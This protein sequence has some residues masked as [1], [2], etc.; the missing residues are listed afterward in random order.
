MTSLV[1]GGSGFIGSWLVDH[2]RARGETVT[3]LTRQAGDVLDRDGLA[4]LLTETKP[5]KI[6]HLAAQ[7][8][9]GPSWNEPAHTFHVNI[10]GTLNLLEAVRTVGL[11]PAIV[12]ACSSSEYK[13][14]D[15]PIKETDPMQPS[16]PYAVSKLGVD[17]IARLYAARYG[18]KVIRARPF[19]LIGPR[20]TGD[21]CSDF[22]RGIVAIEKGQAE[23]LSVGRLDMVRDFLDVRDGATAFDV[24]AEKGKAGEAY[25]ICSGSG[26]RVSDLLVAFKRKSKIPVLEHVDSK[27]IR[28]LDEP[29]KIGDPRKL[30]LLAW[31]RRISVAESLDAIL[32]YWRCKS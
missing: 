15:K 18:L 22:A 3:V 17:H 9:P 28:P 29:V 7:S 10:E 20:K 12:V 2:L 24:L 13:A 32:E 25:N 4:R 26:V 8:L 6:F 31:S 1:T 19:F 5:D 21:V 14:S 16:S 11:K 23:K 27:L 30:R